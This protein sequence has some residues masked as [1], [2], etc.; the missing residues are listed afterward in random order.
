LWPEEAKAR[1]T[2]SSLWAIDRWFRR[3]RPVDNW[4]PLIGTSRRDMAVSPTNDVWDGN[5]PSSPFQEDA[6]SISQR[7]QSVERSWPQRHRRA[8]MARPLCLLVAGGTLYR[9]GQQDCGTNAIAWPRLGHNG[10]YIVVSPRVRSNNC[11][12][13]RILAA[14]RP[15]SA[16]LGSFRLW[17]MATTWSPSACFCAS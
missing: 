1:W 13:S 7:C 8:T 17:R 15:C 16:D 4:G 2:L 3:A 10:T 5:L 12:M 14:Q 9:T 6:H 11:P